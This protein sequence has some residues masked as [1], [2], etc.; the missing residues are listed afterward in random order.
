MSP[1]LNAPELMTL[2][3]TPS[4]T[5]WDLW[6]MEL[7]KQR[8][9]REEF[10]DVLGTLRTAFVGSGREDPVGGEGESLL[11]GILVYQNNSGGR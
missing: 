5:M 2:T 10:D 1:V 9:S 7:P 11:S 4:F 8:T 3:M 6:R